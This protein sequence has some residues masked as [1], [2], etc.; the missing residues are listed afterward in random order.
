M[1]LTATL[2]YG[3]LP[4]FDL[5]LVDY[6][7]LMRPQWWQLAWKRVPI[8]SARIGFALAALVTVA[9]DGLDSAHLQWT[10]KPL[11]VFVQANCNQ[12]DSSVEGAPRMA[13]CRHS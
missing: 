2:T 12:E 13:A 4:V 8:H 10:G 11:D 3:M 7:T 5:M 9:M 6:R 1:T